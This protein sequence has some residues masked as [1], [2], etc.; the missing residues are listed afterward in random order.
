ML[1]W[2]VYEKGFIKSGP[3][4]VNFIA[5]TVDVKWKPTANLDGGA[6]FLVLISIPHFCTEKP[7]V[8]RGKLHPIRMVEYNFGAWNKKLLVER[9]KLHPIR[10]VEYNFGAWNKK[11]LEERG[12][13]HP[14]RMVEY[15]FGAWNKKPLV[16]R[17]K[18]H[19][20]RK[21]EYSFGAWN[22]K[23][24]E[25][26]GKLHPIRWWSIVLGL[27]TRNHWWKEEIYNRSGCVWFSFNTSV[28]S[29]LVE[30]WYVW[31]YLFIYLF[32]QYFKRVTYLARRPVYHMALWTYN[33]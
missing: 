3:G 14:I 20:I 4:C 5:R 7:F 28:A 1:S 22:K 21:V 24:L 17:G 15:S 12:K 2:V 27:G 8:E 30:S 10:K 31:F 19:P 26:R 23:L 29:V 18:L 32:I 25:E 9:G 13:L 6:E 16:E 33:W 11:L